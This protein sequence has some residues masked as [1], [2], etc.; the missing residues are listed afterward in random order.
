VIGSSGPVRTARF[1]HA[2]HG[3]FESGNVGGPGP[4]Q[5]EAPVCTAGESGV[6]EY[7]FST[8]NVMATKIQWR[9][10][11][12][13]AC[14]ALAAAAGSVGA[15]EVPVVTGEHWTTSSEELKKAYLVGIANLIQVETAY[16]AANP[17]P[18]TQNF[19]PRFAKG[20]QGQTL[21]SV[22]EGLNRWYAENPG[23]LQRPVIETI[24]FEIAVPGLA[25]TK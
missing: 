25:K 10:L 18:D 14:T 20:L 5:R 6:R 1:D 22:R 15:A 17:P 3:A 19:V 24:W 4:I 9:A 13:A 12:F 7:F 16:Y 11:M 21:D 8:E 2:G 23:K